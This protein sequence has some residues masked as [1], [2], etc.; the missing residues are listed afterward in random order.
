[1]Q[2]VPAEEMAAFKQ[3]IEG[4]DLTKAAMVEYLK[5]KFPHLYK[6]AIKNSLVQVA[7]RRGKSEKE[8]R[9]FLC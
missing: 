8:K 7:E 4:S 5:K 2:L 1:M 3:A 9:W 6:E